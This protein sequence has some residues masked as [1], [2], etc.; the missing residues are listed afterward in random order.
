[1]KVILT[2]ATGA[3]GLEILRSA[4][5]DTSISRITV[6][7]RRPIPAHVPASEKITRIEHSD[8]LSY[9]PD[10]LARLEGHGACIWALGKSSAG[11]SEDE[12]TRLTHDFPMEALKAFDAAGIRGEDGKFRFVYI[13]GDGANTDEKG[14]LFARVKGRTEKDLSAFAEQ[15]ASVHTYNLRPGYFPTN[16]NDEALV[17]SFSMRIAA[18]ILG[19]A[20]RFGIP[21]KYIKV[22]DLARFCLEAG[23]GRPEPGTFSNVQI[24][25]LL[26]EWKGAETK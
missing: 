19:P 11:M 25:Q 18:R 7:S 5:A 4:I 23:K 26:E 10:L 16:P 6:L 9:P 24:K 2:G 22:E 1:M 12:Y 14:V 17:R 20:I 15:S 8:F 13:S 21:S 3:A